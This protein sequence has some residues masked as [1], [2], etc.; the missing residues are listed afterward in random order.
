M[1]G[2]VGVDLDVNGVGSKKDFGLGGQ[3]CVRGC[4]EA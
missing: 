2:S 4:S 1:E 3:R